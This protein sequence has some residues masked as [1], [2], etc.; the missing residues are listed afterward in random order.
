M[1]QN[2]RSIVGNER[3]AT[4]YKTRNTAHY[5]NAVKL[6]DVDEFGKAKPT[7]HIK[8][9]KPGGRRGSS[10][11]RSPPPKTGKARAAT[12]RLVFRA[13]GLTFCAA[14]YTHPPVLVFPSLSVQRD[15][16][17]AGRVQARDGERGA[18]R[19]EA[20]RG[21]GAGTGERADLPG[22]DEQWLRAWDS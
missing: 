6:H 20:V 15:G 13:S 18:R 11:V 12:R 1:G 4:A 21:E 2:A 5:R 14:A 7:I 19:A 17:R 16:V 22:A 3:G 10:F 9:N 8:R